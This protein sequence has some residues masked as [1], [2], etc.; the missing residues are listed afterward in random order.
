VDARETLVLARGTL[1]ER[2]GAKCVPV[3]IRN[4][5]NVSNSRS[6]SNSRINSPDGCLLLSRFVLHLAIENMADFV[7]KLP[8][9]LAN[10][11]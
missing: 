10:D 5:E 11:L 9:I 8:A 7:S 1:V 2:I 4:H 3:R 6:K